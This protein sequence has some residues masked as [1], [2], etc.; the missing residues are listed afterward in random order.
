MDIFLSNNKLSVKNMQ[1]PLLTMGDM[2]FTVAP[3][4]FMERRQWRHILYDYLFARRRYYRDYTK[5]SP[6]ARDDMQEFYTLNR[7]VTLGVGTYHELSQTW[8]PLL[9]LLID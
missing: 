1:P 2:Y 4:L 8:R 7:D 5:L 3:S 6:E 9:S